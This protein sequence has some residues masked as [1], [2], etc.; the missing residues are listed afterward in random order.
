MNVCKIYNALS[1]VVQGV[2]MWDCHHLLDPA[3]D[4]GDKLLVMARENRK[5][6]MLSSVMTLTYN[7]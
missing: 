2:R 1:W 7:V 4:E 6:H 5:A 3:I